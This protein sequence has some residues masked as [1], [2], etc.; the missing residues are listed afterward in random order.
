M[1]YNYIIYTCYM[2]SKHN[3]SNPVEPN[4]NHLIIVLPVTVRL[5]CLF[6]ANNTCNIEI[7]DNLWHAMADDR[8]L[9][10]EPKFRFIKWW[11]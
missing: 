3:T 4:P 5:K 10:C 11:N 8:V 7:L 6:E 1:Y 2:G 9:W